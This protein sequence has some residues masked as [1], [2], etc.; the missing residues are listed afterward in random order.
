MAMVNCYYNIKK[1]LVPAES[2]WMNRTNSMTIP[3]R[4]LRKGKVEAHGFV[5][6][7]GKIISSED[8]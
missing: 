7:P 1:I 5:S 8:L 4:V 3:A 2:F 6:L